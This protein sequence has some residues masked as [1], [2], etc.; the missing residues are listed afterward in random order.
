[1]APRA[2][3][4]M[5]EAIHIPQSIR[6]QLRLAMVAEQDLEAALRQGEREPIAHPVGCFRARPT[7][8]VPRPMDPET[9]EMRQL[10][11]YLRPVDDGLEVFA[12]RGLDLDALKG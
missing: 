8:A 1:M 7:L 10:E 5:P 2:V 12:V 11:V 6:D 9:A 4:A 3:A